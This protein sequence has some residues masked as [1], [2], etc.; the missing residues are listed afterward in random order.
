[1]EIDKFDEL[2]STMDLPEGR[3]HDWSWLIRNMWI[4]N[5]LHPNFKEAYEIVKKNYKLW[6]KGIT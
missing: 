3:K 1:M 5:S 2:I 4:R 6:I